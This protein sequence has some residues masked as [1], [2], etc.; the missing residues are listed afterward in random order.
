M[1]ASPAPSAPAL[2]EVQRAVGPRYQVEALA[3]TGG[4]G[5]VY[6]AR[7]VELGHTVAIKVLPPEVAHSTIRQARFKR[8]AA[9][10]ARLSHPHI[11]PVYEFETREGL[12]FLIM[13]F[14]AGRTLATV[15]EERRRPPGDVVRV[16]REI[17]AALD[18]A[19]ARGVVHRDVKPSNIL[20]EAGTERALLTD[21]GVAQADPALGGGSLT[22]PGAPI[23]TPDYMAP[24]Q[25][26][27][28]TVD[29]RA[30]LYALAV[31]AFEALT[32][33]LPAAHVE[34]A[35]L[36][37]ALA[38]AQP[39][40][41]GA[42]ARALVA[43][44]ATAPADRPPTAGAWLEAVEGARRRRRRVMAAVT[45][46]ALLGAAIGGRA[47]C[48]GGILCRPAPAGRAIAVM[49]FAVI[50]S[51][52]FSSS[53]QLAELFVSRF[54]PIDEYDGVVSLGKVL[55]RSGPRAV[56]QSEADTIA[57]DLGARY[58]V[59]GDAAFGGDSLHLTARLYEVGRRAPSG[60]ASVAA[61]LGATS[62]ALDRAWGQLL[63]SS[64]APSRYG[65]LPQGKDA[66]VAYLD[67]E[68]SFRDGA[69][70]RAAAAYDQVIALDSTFS[71]ARFRRAL[72][73]AQ[74]DPTGDS[75][76]AALR[77]ALRHQSGLSPADSLMLDGYARLLESGDGNAALSSF[78]AAT[79]AAPDQP[80]AWFVLGEFH[81]HFGAL[82]GQTADSAVEA[83]NHSLDLVPQ[84]A[85]AVAHLIS[86]AYLRNDP[87]ETRRL[88]NQ[89]R[90]LD[91]TSVVAQVIDIADTL[92]F[93]SP[94]AKLAVVGREGTAALER[95]PF[96]VLAFLATE[97]AA[98]GSDADRRGPGRRVL[99]ALQARAATPAQRERALRM[100]VAADLRYGWLDSARARLGAAHSD[101]QAERDRWL[102]LPGA[103][104]LDPLG[105]PPAVAAAADRMAARAR[106]AGDDPVAEWLLALA[107]P[108]GV[109]PAHA[110]RLRALATGGAPLATSLSFDLEARRRLAARDTAGAQAQWE[111]ATRRYEV[112]SVPSGLV[113]SLW[114]IR[115]GELRVAV[116]AGDSTAAESLCGTFEALTGYADQAAWPVVSRLCA[117]ER[118]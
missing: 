87:A 80:L 69:Y 65:T 33:T 37:R 86:F 98:F 16:V 55:A 89:Y 26:S 111:L 22:A 30:D 17:G 109:Q 66:L 19:H 11:V 31:V 4:M 93:G 32:G 9:L 35:T 117:K 83:F 36:A 25:V 76:S 88:M 7:H 12:S 42:L 50:G 59:L 34:R 104:G 45:A 24:E 73:I 116:A 13:P 102:L 39:S 47:L 6:R 56:G 106:G 60:T 72:V 62:D 118:L 107:G 53:T 44:L 41:P 84:Y 103:A 85:P 68:R 57:R 99:R 79:R 115:L 40:L 49:P 48:R 67:A 20:I 52:P 100:G 77:G 2:E 75:V 10:A 54:A 27:A 28:D 97:A 81:T 82:Y 78:R 23:G 74:V 114:P 112:L 92:L 21:F 5:A 63:G 18:F 29:G 94:A 110:A 51:S 3:G 8:E 71:L 1:N 14:V 38:A 101:A 96:E 70:G 108:A 58:F 64:F 90:G 113:A 61:S 91:S 46:L 15:L 105:P 43:P 95:R